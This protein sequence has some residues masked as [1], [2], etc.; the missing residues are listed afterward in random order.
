MSTGVGGVGALMM[1]LH[2]DLT[3]YDESFKASSF[4]TIPEEART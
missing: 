4:E 3:L 2:A 1:T